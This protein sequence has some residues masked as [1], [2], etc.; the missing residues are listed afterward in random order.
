MRC[1]N[2]PLTDDVKWKCSFCSDVVKNMPPRAKHNF[3]RVKQKKSSRK[4]VM[5]KLLERTTFKVSGNRITLSSSQVHASVQICP[6][7][8]V[9]KP[10]KLFKCVKESSKELAE[11][12]VDGNVELN[13]ILGLTHVQVE[14]PAKYVDSPTK[15][16]LTPFKEPAAVVNTPIKVPSPILTSSPITSVKTNIHH[17]RMSSKQKQ[18]AQKKPFPEKLTSAEKRSEPETKPLSENQPLASI[19][20]KRK[21]SGSNAD[22]EDICVIKD[23][24]ACRED[25]MAK[26]K[27]NSILNYF[28]AKNQ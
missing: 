2:L 15:L 24:F 19:P 16:N 21:L 4:V 12:L 3:V 9:P 11:K 17:Q 28:C 13:P 7:F 27:Q 22:N 6:N 5:Q 23:K 25:N 20:L 10:V 14:S 26:L 1:G 8:E 18:S